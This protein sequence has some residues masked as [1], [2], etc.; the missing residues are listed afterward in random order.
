MHDVDNSLIEANR[1]T[2]RHTAPRWYAEAAADRSAQA[3]ARMLSM[4]DQKDAALEASAPL[5]VSRV[6]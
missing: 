6:G 1:W 2:K 4:L 5:L 3:M